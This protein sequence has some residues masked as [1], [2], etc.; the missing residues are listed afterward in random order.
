MDQQISCLC[1]PPYTYTVSLMGTLKNA[2]MENVGPW[3]IRGW[4][5]Q[6]WKT[7]DQIV[8]VEKAGPQSMEREMD[9]YKCIMKI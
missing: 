7:R 6:D 3:K 2:G 1:P 9:K 5:R 8:G 4:K